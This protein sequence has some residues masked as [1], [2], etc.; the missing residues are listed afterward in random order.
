MP[1]LPLAA[2]LLAAVRASSAGSPVPDQAHYVDAD[3]DFYTTDPK[4]SVSY[5]PQPVYLCPEVP[6]QQA[7]DC[8]MAFKASGYVD[9]MLTHT[10]AP[11]DIT[12]R[13]VQISECVMSKLI[14]LD[15]TIKSYCYFRGSL[16]RIYQN[17]QAL[18]ALD[19]TQIPGVVSS[20][21]DL[22]AAA[23]SPAIAAFYQELIA[24]VQSLE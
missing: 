23:P 19:S 21:Q 10:L 16:A 20:L 3:V 13:S 18:N 12:A 14:N 9:Y 5:Q 4:R 24:M 7:Q 17:A 15:Y 6:T 11:A 1:A 2:L 22:A 8:S